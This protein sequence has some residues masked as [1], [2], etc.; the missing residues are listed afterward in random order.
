MRA[1]FDLRTPGI[2]YDD[3]REKLPRAVLSVQKKSIKPMNESECGRTRGRNRLRQIN[4]N[5]CIFCGSV[6]IE[7]I[8]QCVFENKK[9]DAILSDQFE[10]KYLKI[11]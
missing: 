9:K 7:D 1:G 2:P 8:K 5:C 3:F 6:S 10:N 11:Y 4:G